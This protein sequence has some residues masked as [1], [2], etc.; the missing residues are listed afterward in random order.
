MAPD[1]PEPSQTAHR[2]SSLPRWL[3]WTTAISALVIS[4]C[5]IGKDR[6][7]VFRIDKTP[8]NARYW[9]L[10]DHGMNTQGL[11]VEFCYCSVFEECWT[12][13]RAI[14]N[15]VKTCVGDPHLEF[16]PQPRG[17]LA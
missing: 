9:D 16:V 6:V 12:A 4:V 11:T 8:Q 14:R 3:E 10:L 13:A 2:P 15:R 17:P 5:S 1:V 7:Q